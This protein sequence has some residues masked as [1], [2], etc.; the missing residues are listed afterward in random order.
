MVGGKIQLHSQPLDLGEKVKSCVALLRLTG[1]TAGC[2]IKIKTESVWVAGDPTRLEQAINN[3][4]LNALKY[5]PAGGL[6]E[7]TVEAA[8]D[9][10]VLT[11][12]DSG[13]GIS[14]ALLPHIFE[15]FVQGD[16]SLDR[17]KG[18]MGIG[19][20]LV[21]QLIRLHGGTVS[22]QSAGPG[23]GSTFTVHLPCI[24]P[25]ASLPEP[26]LPKIMH[27]KHWR[28][29]MIEDNEDARSMLSQLLQL[30]GHE[31]LEA[32]TAQEGLQL[33][34]SEQPDLVIVDIGLPDMTGYELAEQL[35]A[36]VLTQTMGLIAMTGYGQAEDRAHALAAGFDFHLI[37]PVEVDRLLAVIDRC[38]QTA[39]RRKVALAVEIS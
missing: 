8:S 34:G 7:L 17:A 16:T 20:A 37:K 21:H 1:R 35:R 29:L 38:G 28:I 24:A 12:K 31:V 18:G 11:I 22:A 23:Q 3:L 4:L 6:I 14:S 10:A 13:I 5:T 19:L 2:E 15:L 39:L 9:Q 32:C 25:P 30:E 26:V 33:A 36:N 27:E